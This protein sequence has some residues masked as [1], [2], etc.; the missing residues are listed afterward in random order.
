MG[1][2]T[3]MFLSSRKPLTIQPTHIHL[4]RVASDIYT[5][6]N[7]GVYIISLIK[8]GDQGKKKVLDS[9][10]IHM[11]SFASLLKNRLSQSA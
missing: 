10:Y 9:Q 8:I 2:H 4:R 6:Q 3:W 1:S 7:S 5:R 11:N